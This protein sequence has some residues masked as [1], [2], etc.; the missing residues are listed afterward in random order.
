MVL[1]LREQPL[2]NRPSDSSQV[3]FSGEHVL[4][5]IARTRF[6]LRPID[7]QRG[8]RQRPHAIRVSHGPVV[9]FWDSVGSG[10]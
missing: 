9:G 8:Q 4:T 1:H 10:I 7:C 6:A 5:D 2:S 3:E